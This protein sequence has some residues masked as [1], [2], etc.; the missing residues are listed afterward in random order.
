MGTAANL[1]ATPRNAVAAISA[2]NTNRDGT[3]TVVTVFTAGANGSRISKIEVKAQVTTTNGMVRLFIHN[4]T[5]FFLWKE[6]PVTAATVSAT[7]LAFSASL[8]FS[9]DPLIL[10][11]GYSLRVSTHNAEAMNVHARGGDF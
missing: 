10:P 1:A 4:G 8:D 6:I 11:T 7:V 5:A 9:N 2:A 3:G